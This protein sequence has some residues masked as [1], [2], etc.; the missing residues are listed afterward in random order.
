[1]ST[2]WGQLQ[3]IRSTEGKDALY[4]Y[5]GFDEGQRQFMQV[6]FMIELHHF[7]LAAAVLSHEQF[8]FIENEWSVVT[9]DDLDGVDA[10]ETNMEDVHAAVE[11]FLANDAL[12]AWLTKVWGMQEE[13]QWVHGRRRSLAEDA[14][15]TVRAYQAR[16]EG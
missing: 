2:G 7:S 12:Q 13:L 5:Y 11:R 10:A 14:L 16:L 1:M 6:H 15:E 8:K 3:L 4:R 9:R